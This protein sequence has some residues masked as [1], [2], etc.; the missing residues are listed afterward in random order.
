MSRSAYAYIFIAMVG[1]VRIGMRTRANLLV[2]VLSPS[3]RCASISY[4][5]DRPRWPVLRSCHCDEA[6]PYLCSVLVLVYSGMEAGM[7]R[8]GF[9]SRYVLGSRLYPRSMPASNSANT[10]ALEIACR[11]QIRRPCL[12]CPSSYLGRL[13]A[14]QG[15]REDVSQS[16]AGT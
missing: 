4:L 6:H 16:M 14:R 1:L 5:Y 10:I 12:Y 3:D 8:G 9:N 11:C 15:S 7:R 2:P 13:C